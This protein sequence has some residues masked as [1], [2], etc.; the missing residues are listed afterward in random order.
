MEWKDQ[1]KHPLWQKKRLDALEFYG[2]ACGDCGDTE[3]QLHVHHVRYKKGARIWEY[4]VTELSVLCSECHKDAH[5]AKDSINDYCLMY[6]AGSE[7]VISEIITGYSMYVDYSQDSISSHFQAVG[8]GAGHLANLDVETII[9]FA[10]ISP[11]VIKKFV[12]EN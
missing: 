12:L 3:S 8:F 11:D 5:A 9:K 1:Y 4:E 7:R 2:F 10:S 6:G